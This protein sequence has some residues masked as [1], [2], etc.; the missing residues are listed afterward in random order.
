[1]KKTKKRKKRHIGLAILLVI[2]VVLLVPPLATFRNL[3]LLLIYSAEN[4]K[5]SIAKSENMEIRIPG[6][7]SDL[8]TKWFPAVLMYDPGD[9]YRYLVDPSA[10]VNIYYSFP[11]YDLWK[12]CSALYD[13]S[14]PYYCGFYGAYLVQQD[15]PCGFTEEGE[16]EEESLDEVLAVLKF[17]LFELVLDDFGLTDPQERCFSYELTDVRRGVRYAGWDDWVC[18]DAALMTNGAAHRPDGFRTSYLQYGYPLGMK[19]VEPFAE[20]RLAGR[21]YGRYFEEQNTAVWFYL[22]CADEEVLEKTDANLLS[23]SR[24]RIGAK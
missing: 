20:T 24:I 8:S 15:T 22:L 19:D 5:N 16:F 9:E 23:C 21:L 18:L 11:A 17:D 4:A 13:A 1:M 12:A 6:G 2:L 3:P 7:W 14:S 10:R